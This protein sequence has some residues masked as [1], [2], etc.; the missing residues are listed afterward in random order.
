MTYALFLCPSGFI[1]PSSLIQET[2][3][4]KM[5]PLQIIIQ[6]DVGRHPCSNINA[7]VYTKENHC[8]SYT[9]HFVSASLCPS[10]SLSKPCAIENSDSSITVLGI[11]SMLGFGVASVSTTVL[12]LSPAAFGNTSGGLSG[13]W[14]WCSGNG[15]GLGVVGL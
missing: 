1:Q 11:L 2:P 3:S 5:K 15:G 4:L 12:V 9:R 8:C 10:F 7:L 6:R 13:P 14:T